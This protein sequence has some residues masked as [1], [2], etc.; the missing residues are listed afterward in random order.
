MGHHLSRRH[1]APLIGGA[2]LCAG[3]IGCAKG[4][5]E[6]EVVAPQEGFLTIEGHRCYAPPAFEGMARS[7]AMR[8]RQSSLE[9]FKAHWRGEVDPAVSMPVSDVNAL[10]NQML[11]H[12]D[13][14]APILNED[15]RLCQEWA[16]DQRSLDDYRAALLTFSHTLDKGRCE[17]EAFSLISQEMLI[18][19][20]WQVSLNLCTGQLVK[21]ALSNG[22]YAVDP[23]PEGGEVLWMTAAGDPDGGEAGE[24]FPCPTCPKG[25]V[26]GR[27][28][29]WDGAERIFTV[30]MGVTFEA[31]ANGSLDF[32]LNDENLS[33][34]LYFKKDNL[35][36]FLLIELTAG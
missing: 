28:V 25:A 22:R 6:A 31:E 20:E 36:D 4:P 19:A 33:D 34:N 3:L 16:R 13:D 32:R 35:P 17:P 21:I 26:L 29:D 14:V 1:F 18:K 2:L 9:E 15:F 23:A 8:A 5:V 10:E 7:E 30:G 24:G 11:Q 27:F 12:P